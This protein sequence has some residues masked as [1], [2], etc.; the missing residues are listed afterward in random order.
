MSHVRSREGDPS[1]SSRDPG[2]ATGLRPFRLTESAPVDGCR[3]IAVEG[4]LDMAVADRLQE[5]IDNCGGDRIVIGLEG[6]QFVDS[7]GIAVIL[8]ANHGDDSRIVLHSPSNQV[9]RVFE[10]MGLT[11]TGLVFADR[12]GAL[13]AVIGVAR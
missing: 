6:C 3:E 4:E 7:T 1:S 10:V 5:A 9:L 11:S 8:N 12:E 2:G 13:A